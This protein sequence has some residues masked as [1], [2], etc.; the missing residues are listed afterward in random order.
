MVGNT[1]WRHVELCGGGFVKSRML[2]TEDFLFVPI[3]VAVRVTGVDRGRIAALVRHGIVDSGTLVDDD[4]MVSL[5]SLRAALEAGYE[6]VVTRCINHKSIFVVDDVEYVT[7]RGAATLLGVSMSCVD[8]LIKRGKLLETPICARRFIPFESVAEFLAE[9]RQHKRV[10]T[11][12][13]K[14]LAEMERT[15]RKLAELVAKVG[16][17]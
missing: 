8:E 9:T 15:Q 7:P 11:T 12:Q 4:I 3:Q 2:T 17:R 5:P 13:V 14:L 10:Q 1:A 6:P 16:H